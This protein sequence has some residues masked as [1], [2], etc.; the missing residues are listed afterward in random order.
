MDAYI[1]AFVLQK[2][3][4]MHVWIKLSTFILDKLVMMKD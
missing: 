3:Y 4:G 1:P 2:H